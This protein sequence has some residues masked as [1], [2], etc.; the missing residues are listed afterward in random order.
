MIA[1]NELEK[2]TNVSTSIESMFSR[3]QFEIVLKLLA[4]FAPHV[5]EELWYALGNKK[6]I[7]LSVWPEYDPRLIVDDEVKIIVQVN[8]KVRGSF[9]T[10]VGVDDTK[11]E[12]MAHELPEVKKW[13][14]GKHIKKV[15]VV[16]G[17]LVNIVV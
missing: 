10:S 7:H 5:T 8:G 9:I 15:I 11:I 4:P 2:M 17:K 14:D 1:V 16:K 3:S 6:S 12:Q 13:T